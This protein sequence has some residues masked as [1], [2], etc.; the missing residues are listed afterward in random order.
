MASL[1]NRLAQ[2]AN[3]PRGKQAIR[4]LTERGQ[5]LARDP[6]TRARIEE[7]RRRFQG[8]GPAGG[9]GNRTGG[10]P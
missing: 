1:M 3:S 7:V 6:R 5:Q 8:G 10:R 9:R 2:F 4:Q